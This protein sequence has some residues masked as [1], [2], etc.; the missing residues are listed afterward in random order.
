MVGERRR[1]TH[2][3]IQIGRRIRR[4]SGF[5]T[6]DLPLDLANGVQVLI[7]ANTVGPADFPFEPRDVVVERVEQAGPTA[8][9]RFPRGGRSA[10][11]EEALE[12]DAWMRL[13]W[14]RRR[15]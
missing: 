3:P 10:F 12:H 13:G 6:L 2:R 8:Q 11:A 14:K 7:D 15:R 1:D 9:R 4:R 5:G